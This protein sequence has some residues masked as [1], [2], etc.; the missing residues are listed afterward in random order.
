MIKSLIISLILTI[1]IELLISILI[2]IRKRNDIISI[3]VVNVLTNPIVVFISSVL[4][5]FKITILYWGFVVIIELI[6]VF[7]EGKIYEKILNFKKISGYKLSFINNSISFTIGLIIAILLN[8]KVN[9]NIEAASAF[10]PI[11]Q[12]MLSS[13]DFKYNIKMKSTNEVYE[14]IING[15]ADVIIA[16]KPS[17][18][19]DR[20]IKKSNIE[21]EFKTIYKEPLVI[22][23]NKDNSIDNLNIEQIQDIYYGNSSNMNTYQ[24]EKNNG[25]QT[26]FESIVKNNIINRNHYEIHS[27]PEIIDRV[28]KDKNGIGYAFNSYYSI[29]HPNNKTKAIRVNEKSVEDSDYPLLFEVYMVYRKNSTNEN[30]PKIINWLE[31]EKYQEF[32]KN[33]K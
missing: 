22:L 15:S 3:I 11:S 31:K 18:E 1:F 30:I 27:M 20:M 14:D 10:Y 33:I 8:I 16:T 2:G 17:D 13:Q 12:E 5:S 29:M 24:L 32:V 4:K 28:A 25:S 21:L 6:I 26:C 7:I 9:F 23:L 19:Q